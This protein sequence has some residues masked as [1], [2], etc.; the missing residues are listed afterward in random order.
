MDIQDKL[1]QHSWQTREAYN[2]TLDSMRQLTYLYNQINRLKYRKPAITFADHADF[3]GSEPQ[4]APGPL[5]PVTREN[6]NES[7]RKAL[8]LFDAG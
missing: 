5:P 1:L 6:M 3:L 8:E 7:C 4:S 2:Y